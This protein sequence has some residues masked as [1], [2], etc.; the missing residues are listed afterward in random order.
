METPSYFGGLAD[1][2]KS[3][4]NG[5]AVAVKVLRVY[6]LSDFDKIRRVGYF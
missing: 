4:Y 1:V 2:W 5:R 6:V 3:S